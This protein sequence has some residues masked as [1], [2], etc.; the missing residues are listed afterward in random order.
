MNRSQSMYRGCSK[1]H[2][3]CTSWVFHECPSGA[4][5]PHH[6]FTATSRTHTSL[7]TYCNTLLS[8][9]NTYAIKSINK[10]ESTFKIIFVIR[11][12]LFILMCF[13]VLLKR[14]MIHLMGYVSCHPEG[15]SSKSCGA[16]TCGQTIATPWMRKVRC[17]MDQVLF[18]VVSLNSVFSK[19]WSGYYP[20]SYSTWNEGKYL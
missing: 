6:L 4:L 2:N 11:F 18:S 14:F 16:H 3:Y 1:A 15:W 20:W 17:S 10:S 7:P 12:K 5:G 19:P 8:F 9:G 13:N